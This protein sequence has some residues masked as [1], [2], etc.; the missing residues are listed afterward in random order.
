MFDAISNAVGSG[1]DSLM[2][3]VPLPGYITIMPV[4][5]YSPVPIPSGAPFV[6]MFNPDQW[7]EADKFA[8]HDVQE[9]GTKTGIQRF[10]SIRSQQLSFEILIDGSG[11]SGVQKEVTAEILSLRRTVGFNGNLH[12][13]NKLFIIWGYF[14]FKGVIETLDIQYTLFRPN[15][16]PLRAK[17]KMGFKEDTDAVTRQ[18][19]QNLQSA[20]LTHHRLVKAGDRLDNVSNSIYGSPRFVAEL[21]KANGL[22]TFRTL[23]EG[24]DIVLPPTEK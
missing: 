16:T 21:A 14:I 13:P 17:I 5:K 12:R 19:D 18:L 20:D 23:P 15:G 1:L 7:S 8:Y 10:N 11:A 22:T 4:S 9:N 3:L 24:K 2:N 6:A